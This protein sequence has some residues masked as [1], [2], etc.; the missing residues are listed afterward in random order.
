MT[1]ARGSRGARGFCLKSP[2]PARKCP[3]GDAGDFSCISCRRGGSR[4]LKVKASAPVPHGCQRRLARSGCSGSTQRLCFNELADSLPRFEQGPL[5]SLDHRA[6]RGNH[7]DCRHGCVLT[8]R[9]RGSPA[10]SEPLRSVH[11]LHRHGGVTGTPDRC[12]QAHAGR[13]CRAGIQRGASP[14]PAQALRLSGSRASSL[15]RPRLNPR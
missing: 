13:A 4:A 12:G 7:H 8:T 6:R 3:K 5:A 11:A 14:H 9:A 10:R 1:Q 2:T 15:P